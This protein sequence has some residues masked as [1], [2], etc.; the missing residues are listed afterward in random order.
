[1][2]LLNQADSN[3]KDQSFDSVKIHHGGYDGVLFYTVAVLRQG[4]TY[5]VAVA[6]VNLSEGDQFSRPR[7]RKIALGR[8]LYQAAFRNGLATP[9][10]G[11]ARTRYHN[12]VTIS[13]TDP[14]A[15]AS[16][17]SHALMENVPSF[18]FKENN[19]VR[20]PEQP[21]QAD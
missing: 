20:E 19:D 2:S 7:G 18:L 5:H 1:M 21:N 11:W 15:L 10:S 12:A 6:R 13:G 14:E 17:V 8:A 4:T 3:F 9:R 16:A